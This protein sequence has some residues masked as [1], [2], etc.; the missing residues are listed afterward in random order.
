VPKLLQ[1]TDTVIGQSNLQVTTAPVW[2]GPCS[3]E[4][5]GGVTQGFISRWLCC[6]ERFRLY[7]M[8]GLCGQERFSHRLEYGNLFHLAEETSLAGGNWRAEVDVYASELM[9]RFPFDRDDIVKWHGVCVTQFPIYSGY[10]ARHPRAAGTQALMQEY[11]FRVPYKLPSGRV[12][13]LRGKWDAVELDAAGLWCVDHKTKGE[14][15]QVAISR[16]MQ[17]DLQTMTYLVAMWEHQHQ[18]ASDDPLSA[19]AQAIRGVRYNLIM[20]PMSSE[21]KIAQHKATKNKP[22]ETFSELMERLAERIREKSDRYFVR[23]D[24]EVAP[25]E[26]ERFRAECLDPILENICDDYEWWSHCHE[27]G[28][29]PFDLRRGGMTRGCDF[30]HHIPRHFRMPFGV[31]A[32]E[33]RA[34]LD[35]FLAT[36]SEAGL[37]RTA[38][39][40]PELRNGAK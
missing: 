22:A 39:L 15:D 36:G 24:V 17:F 34:D 28:I 25:A 29:S 23:F 7:V 9:R 31:V 30:P 13:Y 10:W 3:D 16:Q 27:L 35:D 33:Y 26:I 8:E 1:P 5:Q 40:F 20:R 11:E 38:N 14:I 32:L 37:R 19:W 18:Q 2:R 12:V 21:D 6:R 4:L